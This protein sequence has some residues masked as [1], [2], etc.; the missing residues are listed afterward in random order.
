MLMEGTHMTDSRRIVTFEK[1]GK[2]SHAIIRCMPHDPQPVVGKRFGRFG[3][4]VAV[5]PMEGSN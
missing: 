1:N 5:R 3:I 4:V 2:Q